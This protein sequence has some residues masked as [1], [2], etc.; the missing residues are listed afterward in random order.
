MYPLYDVSARVVDIDMIRT[1]FNIASR[2]VPVGNMTP[3]F[4]VPPGG[5]IVHYGKD[6]NFNVFYVGRN[7]AWLQ[8]LRMRWVSDGWATASIVNQGM[9]GGK[10]LYREVSPNYPVNDKREVEWDDKRKSPPE[11]DPSER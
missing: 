6:F 7:G 4:S 11:A 10:E 1:G 3:G 9:G 8:R 2:V 5:R